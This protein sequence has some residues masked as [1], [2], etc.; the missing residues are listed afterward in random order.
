MKKYG[1]RPSK[2]LGQNF[3]TNKG[4]AEKVIKAASID[5][6]DIVLE[7]GP[8]LGILT[9]EL[10]EKAKRVIAVEKDSGLSGLL[11]K[12]YEN[13]KNLEIINQDIL[14]FN[15]D[16]KKYKVV[17]NLPFYITSP[18]I[19]KFLEKDFPPEIMVLI[20]QKEVA[21]RIIAK[22]PKMNLLAVSV[23]VYAEP[24][25]ISYIS[26]GSFY[27]APKVDAA[28]LKL[29]PESKLSLPKLSLLFKI[30][31]AGFSHPRKQL[32]GNLS[33]ELK[34]EKERIAE[35]LKK[36]NIDPARRAE[37]LSMDD[38]LNLSNESRS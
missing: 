22:P 32:V 38:W 6:Q 10:A 15:P 2:R 31:R 35:W 30:A 3:L 33:K 19:R 11:S 24:K 37:T 5:P 27:P 20:V 8:G 34:I 1:I 23:Q 4:I 14:S 9:R 26:K 25:I 7:V 17:A 29:T 13:L 16:I 18:V 36:N 21:Q 12:E 28:I